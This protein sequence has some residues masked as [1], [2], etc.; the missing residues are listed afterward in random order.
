[1]R[2]VFDTTFLG[3]LPTGISKESEFLRDALNLLS[4]EISFR[5]LSP[6]IDVENRYTGVLDRVIRLFQLCSKQ[7]KMLPSNQDTVFVFS[8]FALVGYGENRV[9]IRAHD[10][11]PITN[12]EWFRKWVPAI[13]SKSLENAKRNSVFIIA[14]SHQTRKSL[15]NHGFRPQ[16][17]GVFPCLVTKPE[18]MSCGKCSVCTE[19]IPRESYAIVV[20][21]LEPRKNYSFLKAQEKCFEDVNIKVLIVGGKGWKYSGPSKSSRSIKVCG[22]ICNSSLDALY[23][24]AKIFIS[25]SINEGFNIPLHEALGYGIPCVVSDLPINL[26]E[27]PLIYRFLPGSDLEFKNAL[28]KAMTQERRAQHWVDKNDQVLAYAN[29]LSTYLFE[30]N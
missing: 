7:S 21:T 11:F 27:S 23:Q 20:G 10:L 19:G 30:R 3:K 25:V 16:N 12:P 5:K 13:F 18:G 17:I 15:V 8:Q 6:G 24:N 28:G 9:L 26:I 2:I 4:V 1:M 14:N 29:L 22:K